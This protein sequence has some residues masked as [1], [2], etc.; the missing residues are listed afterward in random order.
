M[1][2]FGKT[3][4]LGR[5]HGALQIIIQISLSLKHDSEFQNKIKTREDTK[6]GFGKEI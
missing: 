4:I 2:L 1:E 6:K 5:V 3:S